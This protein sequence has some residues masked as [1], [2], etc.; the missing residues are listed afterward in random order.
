MINPRVVAR[1]VNVFTEFTNREMDVLCQIAPGKNNHEIVQ[2]LVIS[3]KTAKV[4]IANIL[5]MLH[6][7]DHTQMAAFAWQ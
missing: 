7:S 3:E 1:V 2:D 5:T 4:H 6:L